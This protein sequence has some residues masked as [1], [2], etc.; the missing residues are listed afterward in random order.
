MKKLISG[1]TL[2]AAALLLSQLIIFPAAAA[3]RQLK[4]QSSNLCLSSISSATINSC[5]GTSSEWEIHAVKKDLYKIVSK[6][7]GLCL[8]PTSD[9][10][11]PGSLIQQTCDNTINARL[12]RFNLI[13][14]SIYEVRNAASNLCLDVAGGASTPGTGTLQ[15]GCGRASNQHWL[16]TGNVP[17]TVEQ[18]EF[19]ILAINKPQANVPGVSDPTNEGTQSTATRERVRYW[20]ETRFPQFVHDY[21]NGR[22]KVN[23]HYVDSPHVLTSMVNNGAGQPE[24]IHAR[25]IVKDIDDLINFGWFDGVIVYHSTPISTAGLV[26]FTSDDLGHPIQMSNIKINKNDPNLLGNAP[27]GVAASVHEWLHQLEGFYYSQYPSRTA[28]LDNAGSYGYTSTTDDLNQWLAF[29]RDIINGNVNNNTGLGFGQEAWSTGETMRGIY[30]PLKPGGPFAPFINKTTCL[31][32]TNNTG[33]IVKDLNR[34]NNF[35]RVRNSNG[36]NNWS[37]SGFIFDGTDDYL[38]LSNL[39]GDDFTISTWIKSSQAFPASSSAQA[40]TLL[41]SSTNGI[42]GFQLLGVR[43]SSNRDVLKFVA[44]GNTWTSAV[45]ITNNTW[46][47]LAVVRNKTTG[48]ASIYING[49]FQTDVFIGLTRLNQ[50]SLVSLGGYPGA[51]NYFAG[52]L[53]DFCLMNSA[54]SGTAVTGLASARRVYDAPSSTGSTVYL[55]DSVPSSATQDWGTLKRNQNL[56]GGSILIGGTSFSKGLATHANSKIVYQINDTA[57]RFI[58][59]IGIDDGCSSGVADADFLV[60]GDDNLLYRSATKYDTNPAQEINIDVRGVKT[61]T[62]VTNQARA[63]SNSCDH[64][65]WGAARIIVPS[66]PQFLLKHAGNSCVHPFGGATNPTAGTRSVIFP[67]CNTTWNNL[68]FQHTQNKTL[69][70]ATSDRCL[71]PETGGSNPPLGTRL[72]F[73]A[74]CNYADNDLSGFHSKAFQFTSGGSLRHIS[75]GLCVHPQ[76]GSATP[77]PDTD[78]ILWTECDEPRLAFTKL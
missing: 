31:D 7:S 10:T 51:T 38:S 65:T 74:D 56:V 3:D 43:D 39:V 47:H 11:A 55:S 61:L 72:V 6:S 25:N 5:T 27:E 32:M 8:A 52:E 78:L 68:K 26:A 46:I 12:W 2:T 13:K 18:I 17:N 45:D 14:D 57:S 73:S 58:S 29:L 76:G 30:T 71:A 23:V 24:F 67:N 44:A 59:S 15:W 48:Y 34:N 53:T 63:N 41:S 70:H 54:L 60:Y 66:S 9:S 62:L 21:S 20:A 75:S 37:G 33:M 50:S 64:T 35:A 28:N 4:S 49:V 69:K 16:I 36:N 77:A 22:V 40:V 42:N 19:R 1:T